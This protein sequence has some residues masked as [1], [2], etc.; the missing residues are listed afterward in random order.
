MTLQRCSSHLSLAWPWSS[1]IENIA[2]HNKATFFCHASIQ[3]SRAAGD[4]HQCTQVVLEKLS[5]VTLVVVLANLHV[6]RPI[7]PKSGFL[8]PSRAGLLPP[9]SGANF[10]KSGKVLEEQGTPRTTRGY[11]AFANRCANMGPVS[12]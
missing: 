9:G 4:T 6:F 5:L 1:S 2:H 12:S 7:S 8:P 11:W 10:E 3:D